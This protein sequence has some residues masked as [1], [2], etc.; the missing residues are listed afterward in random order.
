ME[1]IMRL[2]GKDIREINNRQK[3]EEENEEQDDYDKNDD[4]VREGEAIIAERFVM[5]DRKLA[6]IASMN[7]YRFIAQRQFLCKQ[8]QKDR[9]RLNTPAPYL[10]FRH[11][12]RVMT[13]VK[14][15]PSGRLLWAY[16]RFSKNIPHTPERR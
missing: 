3:E 11:K 5:S 6:I 12:V 2:E 7:G 16:L 8:P 15:C 13:H 1:I 4:K 9:C 10:Y 14:R